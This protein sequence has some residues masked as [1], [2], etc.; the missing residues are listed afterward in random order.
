MLEYDETDISEG[1]D[2]NKINALKECKICHYSYFKNVI[3]GLSR[4]FAIVAII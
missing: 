1:I 3:L 4:I 2:I